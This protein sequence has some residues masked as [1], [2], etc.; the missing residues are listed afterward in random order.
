MV[1]PG[2]TFGGYGS[3]TGA[4]VNGGNVAAGNAIPAFAGGPTGNFTII[5]SLLNAGTVNLA[6]TGVPGNQV[7]VNGNYVGVGGFLNVRTVL[8]GDG[9]PSDKLVISNGIGSGPTRIRVTNAGGAGALTTGDGIQVVQAINGATTTPNAFNLGRPVSAGP[10]DYFLFRGG[11]SPG[12]QNSWFLRSS[13]V[14]GSNS[15]VP[16]RGGGAV[17]S[18]LDRAHARARLGRHVQ[19]AAGRSAPPAGRQGAG[20]L[21]P[22]HGKPLLASTLRTCTGVPF[23]R[24]AKIGPFGHARMF[25]TAAW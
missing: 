22:A 4:V 21:G 5:G 25:S 14:P 9:S 17:R 13:I 24:A 23:A 8:A 7:T 11:V 20:R 10:Y 19:R 6:G 12:S 15:A 2:G 1:E 18:A 16:P 3:V